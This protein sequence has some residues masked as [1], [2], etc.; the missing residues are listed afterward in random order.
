MKYLR[1]FIAACVATVSFPLISAHAQS[2]ASEISTAMNNCVNELVTQGHSLFDSLDFCRLAVIGPDGNISPF[3]TFPSGA[4][5]L[6]GPPSGPFEVP[7][8]Q[9]CPGGPL[10]CDSFTRPN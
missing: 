7:N 3:P 8:G 9:R 5:G 2:S 6:S 10:T 4:S 1:F